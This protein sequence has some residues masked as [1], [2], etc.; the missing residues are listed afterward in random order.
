MKRGQRISFH[1]R[2]GCTNT[3]N[4]R[5]P[6]Q[7]PLATFRCQLTGYVVGG[8]VINNKH[9]GIYLRWLSERW[10]TLNK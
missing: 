7:S 9:L 2:F 4:I 3:N 8:Q 5:F 10:N 6:A 1:L